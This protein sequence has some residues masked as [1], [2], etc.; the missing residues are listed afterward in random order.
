MNSEKQKIENLHLDHNIHYYYI[1]LNSSFLY[2]TL[3]CS[4]DKFRNDKVLLFIIF[5][6]YILIHLSC[7]YLSSYY[8]RIYI[9]I[10]AGPIFG[11]YHRRDPEDLFYFHANHP[12]L[13][14]IKSHGLIPFSGRFVNP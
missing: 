2:R 4:S 13:Y 6:I 1:Q 3:Q 7:R 12:F 8:L 10:L 14:F 11:G 9:F 5:V